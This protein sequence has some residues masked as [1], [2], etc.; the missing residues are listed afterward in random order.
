MKKKILIVEDQMI[1]RFM[2]KRF[3]EVN[4]FHVEVASNGID[5]MEQLNL[6]N[7]PDVIVTDLNMP[8]MDGYQFLKMLREN[9][10]TSQVPVIAISALDFLSNDE[11]NG[12]FFDHCITKP[13]KLEHLRI[14]I[15]QVIED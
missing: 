1:H 7:I 6:E 4:N 5:A 11:L 3:L 12:Y 10:V 9:K 2:L 14:E 8:Y 15:M 13:F